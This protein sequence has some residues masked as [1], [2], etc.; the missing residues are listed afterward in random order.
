ML[1]VWTRLG[2]VTLVVRLS[3]SLE[4]EEGLRASSQRRGVDEKTYVCPPG[5]PLHQ[6]EWS[7]AETSLPG[8]RGEGG[9]EGGGAR[10]W[11]G[12]RGEEGRQAALTTYRREAVA[13]TGRTHAGKGP[14]RDKGKHAVAGRWVVGCRV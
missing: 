7:P 11:L 4:R 12:E 2:L 6:E 10:P 13:A 3:P 1:C 8:R 14:E 9:A 5:L